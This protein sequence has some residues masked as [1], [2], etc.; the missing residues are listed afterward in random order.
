MC[1][2]SQPSPALFTWLLLHRDNFMAQARDPRAIT[3]HQVLSLGSAHL[4]QHGGAWIM[5]IFHRQD[6]SLSLGMGTPPTKDV[7][8]K[9]IAPQ[10]LAMGAKMTLIRLM[11]NKVTQIPGSGSKGILLLE[12]ETRTRLG[13]IQLLVPRRPISQILFQHRAHHHCNKRVDKQVPWGLQLSPAHS[14][15][16]M[17]SN[18]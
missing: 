17:S 3:L 15:L 12:Q 10:G 7:T 6:F 8:M 11:V 9:P 1:K 16:K 2:S 18:T 4:L 13:C 5:H 14:A